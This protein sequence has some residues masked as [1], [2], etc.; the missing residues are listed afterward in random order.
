MYQGS[1]W[2]LRQ[3]SVSTWVGHTPAR[4]TFLTESTRLSLSTCLTPTLDL[5]LPRFVAPRLRLSLSLSYPF[6]NFFSPL[7]SFVSSSYQARLSSSQVK[8]VAL[9]FSLFVFVHKIS[10]II[11]CFISNFFVTIDS[12]IC[13]PFLRFPPFSSVSGHPFTRHTVRL[14]PFPSIRFYFY[15][16][17]RAIFVCILFLSVQSMCWCIP[18]VKCLS[19]IQIYCIAFAF[20]LAICRKCYI[21]ISESGIACCRVALRNHM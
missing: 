14:P 21:A 11:L 10:F 4:A 1:R 15:Y 3:C 5:V 18:R 17:P 19:P 13:I 9:I 16:I 8:C 2:W 6:A 12:H 20:D 7:L